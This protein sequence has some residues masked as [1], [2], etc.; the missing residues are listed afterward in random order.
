MAVVSLK[1][2]PWDNSDGLRVFWP[3]AAGTVTRGGEVISGMRHTTEFKL[4]LASL[5]TVA[6]S[7]KQIILEN[8]VF[9]NGAFIEQ[10]DVFVVKETTGTNANLDL[11]FVKTDRSTEL[12]FN[13]LLAAADAFN[14]GTDLG[15]LTAFNVGTTEA[16]AL[17][18]TQLA[19]DGILTANAETAD[20]TAG[21][22]QIRIYWSIPLTADV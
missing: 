9:P 10:V 14:G 20:F 7:N 16:G 2:T 8:C 5:P 12:D 13:G 18:G 17:I 21:V 15:T 4:A 3:G 22:L 19:F 11:G 6:S 1:G